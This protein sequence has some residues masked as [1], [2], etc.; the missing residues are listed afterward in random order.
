MWNNA[1]FNLPQGNKQI[2]VAV[3]YSVQFVTELSYVA[4]QMG[5]PLFFSKS[6][7]KEQDLKSKTKTRCEIVVL[8]TFELSCFVCMDHLSTVSSSDMD[9]RLASYKKTRYLNTYLKLI[10]RN[11]GLIFNFAGAAASSVSP[12]IFRMIHLMM[13]NMPK[14]YMGLRSTVMNI[15]IN[16]PP[17]C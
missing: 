13:Y 2:I 4:N 8:P 10:V 11:G 15:C 5:S 9:S 7:T 1:I 12:E 16:N 6:C 3:S 17:C 14:M